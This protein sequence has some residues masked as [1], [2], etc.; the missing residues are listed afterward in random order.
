MRRYAALGL[1]AI[2]GCNEIWGLNRGVDLRDSG[3]DPAFPRVRLTAQIT[4]TNNEGY[5][6]PELIYGPLDPPPE[7]QI[8]TLD[9]PL[10]PTTYDPDGTV[11]YPATLTGTTW[12]LVY[13]LADDRIPRELQ[14]SP[15]EGDRVAHLV[16][17][18]LGRVDRLPVPPDSGYT[19]TPMGSPPQHSL[20]RVFTTGIWTEGVFTG[21]SSGAT[22]S[23]DFPMK[24]TSLS[25][26]LG[27]PE[28]AKGDHGVLVD[29]QNQD[30][31]RY[32]VGA[33]A[34]VVPDLVADSFTAPDPQPRWFGNDE[35]A[36][37]ELAGPDPVDS[38]LVGVLGARASG[39]NLVR[40]Q[41]GYVP[42]LDVFG[43]SKPVPDPILDFFLPGPR[44][45]AF[46][47]CTFMPGTGSYTTPMA[48]A[49]PPE[50]RGRF[51]HVVHV[52]VANQ[53]TVGL[54]TLT[55]GFSAVLSSSTYAFK[56]EFLVAAA[57]KMKLQRDGSE[58][59]LAAAPDGGLLPAGTGPLELTFDLEP[60][61]GLGADYFEI[62]LY[63]I[64]NSKLDRKRV[65]TVMERKLRLDPSLLAR[66]TEYVFEIRSY[67]GRPDVTRANFAV[68]TYPQYAAAIFTRT[69]KT[70]P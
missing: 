50:L 40:M 47:N 54:V 69:F 36:T 35:Q 66:N 42:S 20:S 70:P 2:A 38:R 31:C 29:F 48:F 61:S 14:W 58:L 60:A 68:N 52:E 46:A 5:M 17:P 55:S 45:I 13:T 18:L 27:A 6:D 44:M 39:A 57:T 63:A 4:N 53:R 51:P 43:F 11:R 7:V 37:L 41:Y 16:E 49:D 23:Y 56:S 34:F 65:Y 67:R 1:L 3:F 12:R 28:R 25:G 10:E 30:G 19:I 59:D 15:P 26:R 64:P 22:F 21:M 24:A 9:G 32:A 33:A 8:G 62:T